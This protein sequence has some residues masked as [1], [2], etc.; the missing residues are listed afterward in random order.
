MPSPSAEPGIFGRAGL[1]ALPSSK[2]G[3]RSIADAKTAILP[4]GWTSAP[5]A[6]ATPESVHERGLGFVSAKEAVE[7]A[8]C[9]ITDEVEAVSSPRALARV[10]GRAGAVAAAPAPRATRHPRAAV[11]SRPSPIGR[12][13]HSVLQRAETALMVPPGALAAPAPI[14]PRVERALRTAPTKKAPAIARRTRT[15]PASIRRTTLL[16]FSLL[17]AVAAFAALPI[18]SA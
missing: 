13:L 8:Q 6:G 12:P 1:P 15:R 16:L 14:S 2:P 10:R 17:I 11:P 9:E 3:S 18:P 7:P 5:W 4:S